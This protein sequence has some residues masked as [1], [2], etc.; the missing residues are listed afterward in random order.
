MKSM[1]NYSTDIEPE[2]WIQELERW[3]KERTGQSR[4]LNRTILARI[5]QWS[6]NHIIAMISSTTIDFKP[7]AWNE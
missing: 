4:M 3:P 2:Q 6:R 5:A 1:N 7:R